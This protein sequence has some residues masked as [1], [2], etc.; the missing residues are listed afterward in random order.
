MARPARVPG[1]WRFLALSLGLHAITLF[2]FA[3]LAPA[4]PKPARQAAPLQVIFSSP[5]VPRP[6]DPPAPTPALAAVPSRSKP[7]TM[8]APALS[9]PAT[10]A[11][12]SVPAA[13]TPVAELGRAMPMAAVANT[14][15]SATLSEATGSQSARLT[16]SVHGALA[17]AAR[18]APSAGRSAAGPAGSGSA[19]IAAEATR[20]AR[21]EG[22]LALAVALVVAESTATATPAMLAQAGSTVSGH[23]ETV[24]LAGP[25]RR[26]SASQA[27]SAAVAG[28][29]SPPV[30]AGEPAAAAIVPVERRA[31]AV[32]AQAATTMAGPRSTVAASAET[33]TD[34][35]A[36]LDRVTRLDKPGLIRDIPVASVATPHPTSTA[37]AMTARGE[38]SVRVDTRQLDAGR[39]GVE[40]AVAMA[41]SAPTGSTSDLVFRAALAKDGRPCFRYTAPVRQAG[42]E[43]L[44]VLSIEVTR[45]GR[46]ARVRISQG[47]GEPRLD[48]L[49]LGQAEQCARF[50]VQ[51]RRGQAITALLQLPV[52]YRLD[53]D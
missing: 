11:G 17:P 25:L 6:A 29:A 32:L 43:G 51:N 1:Q 49:A 39:A 14:S 42:L 44:V 18:P 22:P 4:M 40:R 46:P 23:A 53:A 12:P 20:P 24:A 41:A 3:A 19:A 36:S 26:G 50:L 5:P 37:P 33:S 7:A 21:P 48:E 8:D 31:A 30:L 45:E 15:Q 38:A 34:T 47:S 16:G 10:E 2:S 28:P 27:V 52:R 9:D 13:S 35:H